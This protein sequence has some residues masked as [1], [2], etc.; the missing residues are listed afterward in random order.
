MHYI[1][2]VKEEGDHWKY[3]ALGLCASHPA[4]HSYLGKHSNT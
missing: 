4:P 2:G 1:Q 3:S